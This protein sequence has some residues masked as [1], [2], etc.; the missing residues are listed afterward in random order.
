M[1][2][3]VLG[4]RG[5]IGS[6]M[7]RHLKA[8]GHD[9]WVPAR[10]ETIEPGTPAGHVIYAIGLTGDFRQH[11]HET[12]DAHVT[13]LGRMMQALR[14]DSWLYLSSTRVYGGLPA[15]EIAT[16]ATPLRI[17]PNADTTYDLSKLLGE[18]MCLAQAQKAVR[19]VRLS[20]VFGSGQSEHTFLGALLREARQNG[21][22][23]VREAP[24][25]SKDY[26]AV[27][28]VVSLMERITLEGRE[29]IY[30]IASGTPCTHAALGRKL[31]E[32]T[33]APVEFARDAPLRV[34]PA[35]DIQ[36]VRSE[37][38]FAPNSVLEYIG[39]LVS[40]QEKQCPV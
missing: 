37:F 11:L 5:F 10:E 30:N 16:E 14:F 2:F 28:A 15:G 38:G 40:Q 7:T 26:V 21:R 36:R 22:V 24:D 19:V 9:V 31:S 32:V 23:I 3:T 4:G 17:V 29:R 27:E 8:R 13:V 18:A 35:I 20:N 12:I 1:K 6:H 33:G 34:F 25:S 39:S